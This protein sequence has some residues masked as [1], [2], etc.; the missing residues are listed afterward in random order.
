MARI[1]IIQTLAARFSVMKHEALHSHCVVLRSWLCRG[2]RVVTTGHSLGAGVA[3]L[4]ALYLRNFF[5]GT[6]A[7]AF[8]PPGGLADA[9]LADA[10]QGCVTSVVLGKDW[11]PRLTLASFERLF[12]EMVRSTTA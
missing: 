10:A 2:W 1:L 3:A 6:V 9:R 5:P 11:V 7:W 4:V 12:D 8:E